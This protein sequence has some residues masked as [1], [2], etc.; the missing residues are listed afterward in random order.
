MYR[1]QDA[2]TLAQL[3]TDAGKDPEQITEQ[4]LLDLGFK[5]AKAWV[6]DGDLAVIEIRPGRLADVGFR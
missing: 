6:L 2:D 5:P 3:L 4:D 1:I